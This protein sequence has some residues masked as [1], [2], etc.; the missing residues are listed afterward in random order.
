MDCPCCGSAHTA[1][2]RQLFYFLM[3][4]GC[5]PRGF[6]WYSKAFPGALPPKSL[7]IQ[8]GIVA[9][10]MLLP[11]WAMSVVGVISVQWLSLAF[12]S[13]LVMLV[14]CLMI[15][16]LV[17]YRRYRSWSEQILC[18]HCQASFARSQEIVPLN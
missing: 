2:R 16:L 10:L 9:L 15:D 17:T 3:E 7:F 14:A 12:S 8:F 13:S 11:L 1:T 18:A 4:A 6:E 5:T